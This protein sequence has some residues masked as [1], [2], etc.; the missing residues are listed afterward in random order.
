[1]KKNI[2]EEIYRTQKLMGV[3]TRKPLIMEQLSPF[4][5]KAIQAGG[6]NIDDIIELATKG[7]TKGGTIGSK[8]ID[9]LIE[10]VKSTKKYTNEEIEIL[11]NFLKKPK[12]TAHVQSGEGLFTKIDNLKDDITE[13]EAELLSRLTKLT[14]KQIVDIV[15]SIVAKYAN[16]ITDLPIYLKIETVF[17]NQLDGILN[18]STKYINSIDDNIYK[19]IDDYLDNRFKISDDASDVTKEVYEKWLNEF[20]SKVRE[21][22]AKKKI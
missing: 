19:E 14:D 21:N 8:E 11:R 16:N 5:I 9:D 12:V 7:I 15:S 17:T 22:S 1:M 6:K 10:Y 3:Q 20:K 13:I 18:D 2:L 4:L